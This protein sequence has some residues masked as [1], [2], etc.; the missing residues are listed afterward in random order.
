MR[1]QRA[2]SRLAISIGIVTAVW[3]A[4][5]SR[6]IVRD[7]VVPW[8]S[9]NQFYAFFRFLSATLR[10]GEWPFW[11]P[12][13][14]SGHP[15]VADPQS[16]VFAPVFVAWGLLDPAPTM[17]AFDLVIFGHL[18]AGGI[19]IAI[20]GW[21]ARWPIPGSVLAAALFMFGGAASGRLQ[22]S[23]IILSYSLFPLALLLLTLA[24]ERRSLSSG[25]GF[26][27]TAAGIALGRNQ[28]A[29]LLCVLL[30]AAGVTEILGSAQPVRYLRERA[31][32]LAIMAAAGSALLAV[33]M[34]LTL[35]FAQLSNRPAESLDDALRGSLYLGNLATLMVANIFGTHGVSYWGPGAATLPEVALTDDSENYLFVGVVPVLLLLWFGIVGGGLWR[36]GRRLM[37]CTLAITCLF[38]LG[39]YTPFYGLAFRFVPGI[40]LFRRPTD[41]SFLFG[42]A[43]AFLA[44]HSLAD[45]VREGLPPFRVFRTAVAASATMLVLG[46]AVVFSARTGHALDAAWE[47]LV[48]V[49][50][51]LVAGLILLGA[52]R[53]PVRMVAATLLA[54][55]GMTELVWWNAA[56]RLNA[57]N[58]SIYEV[59]EAPTGA[60]ADAIAT[61][62]NA[63]AVDHQRGIRP[64]VE[65][66]GLGG[67]W[68]NL[69]M[70]RGWEAINGYNPLRIGWYDRLVS[71]GEENWNVSQR[72]FPPSFGN[73]DSTLARALGL[74]YLV[75][76]QPLDQLPGLKAPPAAELLRSG[77]RVWIYRLAGAMPRAVVYRWTEQDAERPVQDRSGDPSSIDASAAYGRLI[78]LPPLDDAAAVT[79]ESFTPGRVELVTTSTT[80]GLLVLH[81]LY[82][83]GWIAEVDGKPAAMMRAALLFR[84]VVVPA[85]RHRVS[86]RFHPFALSN[87]GA[88]A[89]GRTR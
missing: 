74:T 51:M 85:G 23:G 37:T 55:L 48:A 46:S 25:I 83:P 17:R 36:R 76:G 84:G 11:N 89:L 6:W 61:L 65:V 26:A 31:G 60:E 35:Q 16:L 18:L 75:M 70:V 52:R 68:Q 58:R 41:A 63:I 71:P 44:G 32:V 53:R 49:A 87:L 69:A 38:M 54:L 12:Y 28:T 50:I 24:L 20:I 57:E 9:K 86:F 34:L 8:D 5:V 29:L 62:D 72:Q 10:A 67:P 88:A 14:Y 40:D 42:I 56:S 59:L 45:Y 39:R 66:I 81:D 77:P 1:R 22:H 64:R 30:A 73:Y 21:R 3:L 7:A 82:Y 19:A 43:L 79:I 78:S 27:I 33:P 15:S 80:E 47:T 2:A 4:G 13:H